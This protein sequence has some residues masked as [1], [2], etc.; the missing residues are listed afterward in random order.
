MKFSTS[1][2]KVENTI[3]EY[4][5]LNDYDFCISCNN[6]EG[7]RKTWEKLK[8]SE[9]SYYLSPDDT[10]QKYTHWQNGYYY[11]KKD[12]KDVSYHEGQ[13]HK[14]IATSDN[15][16]YPELS[17]LTIDDLS[18]CTSSVGLENEVSV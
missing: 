5:S 10:I 13:V 16:K 18:R 15:L 1:F 3:I 14:I 11:G 8:I 17:L 12:D 6:I 7:G 4:L 2:K 9:G